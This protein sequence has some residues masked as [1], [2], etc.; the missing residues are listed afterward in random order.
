MKLSS[1]LVSVCIGK[2]E[3]EKC[4]R[5]RGAHI[6]KNE[7]TKIQTIKNE[8]INTSNDMQIRNR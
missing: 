8:I 7:A 4:R 2:K 1:E 5:R 3:P 6:E